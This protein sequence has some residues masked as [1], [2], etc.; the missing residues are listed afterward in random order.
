MNEVVVVTGAS[1]GVGR[2][3]VRRFARQ[4]AQV[5]LIARGRERLE[6][7]RKEVEEA[8]GQAMVLPC[9]VA[10]AQAVELA[11][12]QIEERFGPIDIWINDAMATVFAEF[13]EI[14]ADEFKRVTE[15]TYLGQVYGTMAALRRMIA[16]D[17]G[18]IVNVGSALAYRGIPLQSAYCGAKH[19]IVGFTDSLRCELAHDRRNIRLTVVHLPAMN[20]PQF[21]WGRNKTNRKAQPVPPIFEPEVAAD[22]IYWAAHH[23]RREVYVGGPTFTVINGQKLAPGLGDRYLA[24]TGYQSQMY[25]GSPPLGPGNLFEPAPGDFAARGEFTGRASSYSYYTWATLHRPLALAIAAGAGLLGWGLARQM[26][27]RRGR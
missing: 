13:Q 21:A 20:T 6:A 2:A 11:A 18:T 1:A 7:A 22:A 9:D 8:G 27:R 5:A 10:D 4:K 12:Q 24:R 19:A 16:R 23:D 25:D 14:T 26:G 17:R 15:V 3:V